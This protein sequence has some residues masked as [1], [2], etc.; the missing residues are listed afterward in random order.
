MSN[1]NLFLQTVAT[2]FFVSIKSV[3]TACTLASVGVY[4]HQRGFVVGNGKRTLALISQQVTIPLLFFT[5]ILYCNQ[6]WSEEPC[7]NVTHSLKDVWILL[8]W[9]IWVCLA[10]ILVGHCIAIL[11]D[12]EHGVVDLRQGKQNK[13]Q[14]QH[15]RNSILAAVAFGNST[16]LPITLLTVIHSNFGGSS[17]LGSVDPTLFLSVYL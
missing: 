1:P 12:A 4:L 9:P 3:G 15:Q 11:A 2:T 13:R 6:D 8:V 5:K 17:A 7:P 10:G 14:Q 16:G